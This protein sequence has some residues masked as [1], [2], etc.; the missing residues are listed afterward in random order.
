MKDN[1][2]NNGDFDN[3][4]DEILD[5]GNIVGSPGGNV[6]GVIERLPISNPH[7]YP[8]QSELGRVPFIR[9]KDMVA[10][11]EIPLSIDMGFE[12]NDKI[13]SEAIKSGNPVAFLYQDESQYSVGTSK[14]V[15]R[16]GVLGRVVK[17]IAL[18]DGTN[19]LLCFAGPRVKV[20]KFNTG[21]VKC[22]ATLSYS[23]WAMDLDELEMVAYLQV[24]AERTD[25]YMEIAHIDAPKTEHMISDMPTISVLS[26]ISFQLPVSG[27]VKERIISTP[28]ISKVIHEILVHIDN[29][30]QLANI[31]LDIAQKTHN[32]LGAQQKEA[33]L[34]QQMGVIREEL[35]QGS[36]SDFDELS[37]RASEKKWNDETREHFERE[38]AKL[39]RHNPNSPDYSIQYSYLDTF[40][41]L[42]W[43]EY[44][45]SNYRFEDI[46]NVLNR[47]HYGLERVKERIFEQIA[48][49]TLRSDNKAPILCLVGPPGVGKTSLG[50]SIAEAMG[51]EY[52]RVSFGGMHDEAEIRGHRRTYI[53]AMPGRI[54]SALLKKRY[55]N[56]LIVL[57][58]IDKI[59]KDFKGDP[60]T[61]LLEVLDPEQNNKFHDNY[62]DADYDLS[63]VLFIAT[64]NSLE[65]ISAPLRDRMEI[66]SIP[67]YITEEK[68]KIANRHLIGKQLREMGLGD[69]DIRFDRDALIYII[70]YYTR[71]SG[72]RKLEKTIAKVLRKIAVKKVRGQEFPRQITRDIVAEYLGKVEFNPD[73][74]ENNDFV[75]VVTGLAWTQVGGEILFIESSVTEGK[76]ELTLT[77]NLGNVMKES[78][79][80]AHQY[81]KAHPELIG[82]EPGYFEKH[83]VHIHVPEGAIPKDGPSAGI[84]MTTSL[85]SA[86]SGRKVKEK[87]AMTGEITLRGKVLPV[88]GIKEKI[89][90]AKRAGIREII[91][92]EDNRK[93]IE[94]V[95]QRYLDG[96]TITY[97]RT[98][99]EVLEHALIS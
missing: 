39:N 68:V 18:P 36:N 94:E 57:D 32:E 59:G 48:V 69:E 7:D 47:D 83:N 29:L 42:P 49:A 19:Q 55:S 99:N 96:L 2:D 91:L 38:L 82:V 67:G 98:I 85:A 64:A 21:R 84:T 20:E 81:L 76:G 24:L 25:K 65:T 74:Y 90:A 78:A 14:G 80:I 17:N 73:M 8:P 37:K 61:A 13:V 53:G 93:D 46:E 11:P 23:D 88:G 40:L 79:Q 5:A 66:I 43:N 63:N 75:G 41:S 87:L 51:R 16:Y 22:T 58:E 95:Q 92:S 97:V 77:G 31:K 9:L 3:L 28:A 27:R 44:S 56:P 10:F 6:S 35:G 50:K 1:K 71:E 52:A 86:F 4:L 26:T 12:E 34:Q 15:A 62:V 89:I 54:M 33:F 45:E 30:T 72:V 70:D 60:S